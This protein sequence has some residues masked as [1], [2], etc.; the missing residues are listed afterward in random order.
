MKKYIVRLNGKEY[1]VEIEEVTRDE[2]DRLL[3]DAPS[4]G[5]AG[6]SAGAGAATSAATSSAAPA[7]ATQASA[8]TA[9]GIGQGVVVK[10]PMPGS[11]NDVRVKPGDKVA[12]GDVLLILEA[13]KMMNEIVSPQAGTVT[14]LAVA[15]GDAVSTGDEMVS[16]G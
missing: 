2:N 6:G 8:G 15:K 13:M 7:A 12:K 10:A 3:T 11:I 4:T 14:G 5:A 9:Q 1:E 16:I